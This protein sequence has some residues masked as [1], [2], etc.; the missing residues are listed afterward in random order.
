MIFELR[1][2]S[3]VL[4]VLLG[5]GLLAVLTACTSCGEAGSSSGG[6]LDRVQET[7]VLRVGYVNF[8]PIV[9]R[10]P[11]TGEVTG[12]FALSVEE[13]ASQLEVDVEYIEATWQTFVAGL[14]T[15]QYDLSVAPTFSTIPR[16]ASVAF[17]DPLMYVGNSAIIR[18][19]ETRFASLA[20]IDQRS[21]TVAVTEGEAGHEYATS[22][23]EHARVVVQSQGDQNLAFSQVVAGRADVALGDAW[24]TSQFA[25]AHPGEVLDLFAD[26][27]YNLTAVSWAV[28]PDDVQFL[29]F[30]NTALDVL[31]STGKLAEH[32]SA[33]DAHWLHKMPTWETR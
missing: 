33:F 7:G 27:P 23:F 24:A 12:H 22:N 18:R 15:G 11:Q 1:S 29:N 32:E 3:K 25:A 5:V 9:F 14:Q 13:I 19:G 26:R 6:S 20:D 4:L 28:R 17:S 30:I 21:I 8:P 31:E 10:D 16:A 2:Q